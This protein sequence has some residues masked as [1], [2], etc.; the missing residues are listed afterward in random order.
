MSYNKTGRRPAEYAS[1]S[2]HSDIINDPSV[3][4]FLNNCHF[5]P[6]S[7]QVTFENALV[8]K[9]QDTENPIKH[10]IA[11]D[12][13]YTEVPVRKEFPSALLAFFQFGAL[14]FST[15]ELD[16]IAKLPFIE[17]SDMEKLKQLERLKLTI[18]TKNVTFK[19]NFN[20]TNSVRQ[21]LHLF[22]TEIRESTTFA[23]TLK[24]LLYKEFSSSPDPVWTL[25]QCPSCNTRSVDLRRNS[26]SKD[27]ITTCPHC[28]AEIYLI[29]TLRLHE[30]VDDELGAGG[31][32]GYLMVTLE[33]ILLVHL[34]KYV[35][36]IK[37]DLLNDFL[38]IKDGPLAFFGQTANIHKPMRSLIEHLFTNHN[39]YLVGLE[40]SGPFVDHAKQ[41]EDKL[42]PGSVLI[43]DNDYIYKYIIPGKA[44]ANEP[45]GRT[46][47]YGN[48]VIYKS[49]NGYIYVATL[50]TPTL[51]ISP[52]KDSFNGLDVICNNLTRLK[53]DMYDSSLFP[54]AL[55]NKLVSLSNHPSA[56]IL[57]HFA[58]QSVT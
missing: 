44:N 23:E 19:D 5:P 46:T 48:K 33:Q 45:Y 16:S 41:I 38:F 37:P 28:S 52:T 17:P 10:I 55:A 26:F 21:T 57:E 12:G 6:T 35:L 15:A 49:E 56:V 9:V 39:L 13:G 50:P 43:L 3:K 42:D 54:V 2:S 51:Q 40:K 47:Y 8:E 36:E 24:W 27:Y 11:I 4:E 25:S 32:L 1:R 18:P 31:I 14:F 58:K 7:D 30:A 20:L 29:D 22:F 53:C 34:I